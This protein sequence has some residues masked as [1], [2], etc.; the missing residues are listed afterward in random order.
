MKEENKEPSKTRLH[1]SRVR[2]KGEPSFFDPM[3]DIRQLLP[4]F[5][6]TIIEG[7][8]LQHEELADDFRYLHSCLCVFQLRIIEDPAPVDEQIDEF[9]DALYK[10]NRKALS[11][12]VT[13]LLMVQF[14]VYGLFCRRNAKTD[15]RGLRGMLEYA[16]LASYKSVL[17]PDTYKK[18]QAELRA[19]DVLFS[20]DNE[21]VNTG[22]AVCHETGEILE[23][24]QAIAHMFISCSGDRSWKELSKA[25]DEAYEVGPTKPGVLDRIA[26]A[27][28]YPAYGVNTLTVEVPEDAITG[29]TR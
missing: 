2:A 5:A 7:L 14:T 22:F 17:S 19:A 15:S 18:M 4:A 9:F 16:A 13:A 25:C 6:K 10:C 12:W 11:L 3:T 21:T 28:A 8:E 26:I 29:E 24:V 23:S 27:L 20:Q 1:F